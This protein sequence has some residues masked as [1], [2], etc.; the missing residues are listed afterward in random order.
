MISLGCAKNLVDTEVALGHFV[1][2]GAAITTNENDAD[3]LIVNTCGFI[4]PA[5]DESLGEIDAALRI[6]R[7]GRCRCLV[8]AGCLV[9]RY[10][11][12]L[13]RELPEV[14]RFVGVGDPAAVVSAVCDVLGRAGG[15][16]VGAILRS[17]YL[18]DHTTP[19]V[20]ATPPWYAWVKVAEGC[21][22]ECAFCVIPQIRGPYRSRTMDS[23]VAEVRQLVSEGVREVNL[24]AQDTTRFGSDTTGQRPRPTLARLLRRLVDETDA[25]WVR[26]LYCFPDRM[27]EELIEVMGSSPRI[28]PYVDLP[29]QHVST[30]VLRTMRRGG[31][32]AKYRDLIA[33]IRDRIPGVAVR[34]AFIV[35]FP[36]ETERRF[37]QLRAFVEKVRFDRLFVFP[38][39]REEGT[40]AAEMED[41]V[42]EEVAEER[43]DI[44]MSLQARIS[45][46]LNRR[47]VGSVVP[48]LCETVEGS[49][50]D[51][52]KVVVGRTVRDAPEV[53]LGVRVVGTTARPG[54]FVRARVT[55]AFEYEMVGVAA[56]RPW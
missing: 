22:H 44:L 19:R 55:K 24:I 37:H 49:G 32:G 20:R 28:A 53:D 42:A 11:E 27:T 2:C 47:W 40:A 26:V 3:V 21:D 25:A 33:R 4:A 15:T 23:V 16:D 38:F 52:R 7:E 31:S 39:S 30:H 9:E 13:S 46:E 45:Q 35:G 50:P 1:R 48:V 6:R 56:G 12:A 18:Y 43:R 5:R 29:L 34:T 10:R 36:G 17:D 54:Q 14:D 51:R 8:V 41:Q